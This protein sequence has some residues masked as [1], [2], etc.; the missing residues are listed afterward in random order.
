NQNGLIVVLGITNQKGN[1]NGNNDNQ[2]RIQLQAEEVDLMAATASSS[3]TQA[4]KAPVYDSD[5][6]AEDIRNHNTMEDRWV[7][8]GLKRLQGFLELLLLSTAGTKVNAAGLQL[9]EDLL[10]PR[11]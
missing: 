7:M 5:G 4:N 6:S 3:S 9:L 1:G 2:I 8:L 10:L 11:G